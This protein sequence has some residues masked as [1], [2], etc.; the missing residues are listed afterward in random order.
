MTKNET[1]YVIIK[2]AVST[3]AVLCTGSE[4]KII[5]LLTG[6]LWDEQEAGNIKASQPGIEADARKPCKV[7]ELYYEKI[8]KCRK[9]GKIIRTA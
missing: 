7:H 1:E 2:N 8:L 3:L 4:H 6:Y 5:D 9:C